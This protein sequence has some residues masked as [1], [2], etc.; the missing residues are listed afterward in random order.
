MDLIKFEL[1]EVET[2][3]AREFYENHKNCCY[4]VLGKENFSS[5]GGGFSF[6]I[7]PT[8]LGNCVSIRCNSC[9]ETKEITNVD[10]W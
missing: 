3:R 5:I 7:S 2:A 8:G 6:T 1:D 10:N 4:D 9:Y